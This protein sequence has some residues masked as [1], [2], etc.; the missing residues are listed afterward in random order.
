MTCG[1]GAKLRGEEPSLFSFHLIY[2][3]KPFSTRCCCFA[4]PL[5]FQ[6]QEHLF[7]CNLIST[8]RAQITLVIVFSAGNV[9]PREE[10]LQSEAH[11]AKYKYGGEG[12]NP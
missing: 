11:L 4:S 6:D 1:Q 10:A 5:Q 3:N 8:Q 12:G 9:L 2:G 7:I